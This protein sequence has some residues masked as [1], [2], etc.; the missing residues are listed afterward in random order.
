MGL[1][2]QQ[3]HKTL[4]DKITNRWQKKNKLPDSRVH[5]PGQEQ[6]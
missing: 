6:R 1:V 2:E 4:K 3:M 5:L